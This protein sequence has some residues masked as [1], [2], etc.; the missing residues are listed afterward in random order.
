M[1]LYIYESHASVYLN[2]QRERYTQK[3]K[4]V[5]NLKESMEEYRRGF[6][7]EKGKQEII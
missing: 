2:I 4:E 1:Y 7:R 6:G 3:E 5:L